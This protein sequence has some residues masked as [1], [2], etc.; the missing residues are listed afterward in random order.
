MS[1]IQVQP[2]DIEMPR[3]FTF[4][5]DSSRRREIGDGR[6][7]WQHEKEGAMA[8]D[9][10]RPKTGQVDLPGF[11]GAEGESTMQTTIQKDTKPDW[12]IHILF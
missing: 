11:W 9:G 1:S 4:R 8:K 10:C 3:L 6:G 5:M 12:G 2:M 7:P